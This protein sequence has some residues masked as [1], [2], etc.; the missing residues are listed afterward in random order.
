MKAVWW[1]K[2]IFNLRWQC[3]WSIS[4][5]RYGIAF[6]EEVIEEG[7]YSSFHFQAQWET[8]HGLSEV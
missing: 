7:D 6:G 3:L 4:S 8:L 5:C 1:I 2:E